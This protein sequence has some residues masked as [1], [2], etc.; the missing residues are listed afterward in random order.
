MALLQAE[1][2]ILMSYKQLEVQKDLLK[3]RKK[4]AALARQ[5]SNVESER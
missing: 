2:R 1:E 5:L 4:L 3:I